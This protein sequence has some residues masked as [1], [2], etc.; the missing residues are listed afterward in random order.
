PDVT[1]PVLPSR[2]TACPSCGAAARLDADWCGQCYHDLRPAPVVQAPPP[3]PS[4]PVT[5]LPAARFAVP[6]GDPLTQPL[7]DFLPPPVEPV[8]PVPAPV[9]AAAPQALPT[10]T[11]HVCQAANV[12][13]ELRCGT[14]GG[15]FLGSDAEQPLLVLPGVGDVT[16]LSRGQRAGLA[17]AVLAL[18]LVPLALVTLVL[19]GRPTTGSSAPQ[20][21]V[22]TTLPAAP[23][24][25]VPPGGV[26]APSTP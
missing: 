7:L 4:A 20:P 14:C 25:A 9:A 23:A 26:P 19:T 6:A 5:A 2:T 18:V 24:P 15:S 21:T 10:W 3:P 8:A 17:G 1:D 12:V 16:K 22:V 11:C 13:T